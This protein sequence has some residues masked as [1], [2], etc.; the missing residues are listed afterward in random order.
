MSFFL[1]KNF[2]LFGKIEMSPLEFLAL[3]VVC[4]RFYYLMGFVGHLKPTAPMPFIFIKDIFIVLV[5]CSFFLLPKA[6]AAKGLKTL[7]AVW[8]TAFGAI[9][10]VHFFAK[11]FAEWGQ[12]Y[13]RNVLLVLATA[14]ALYRWAA[15]PKLF[16]LN[17]FL[18]WACAANIFAA[19]LQELFIPETMLGISRPLGLVGDPISLFAIVLIFIAVILT[20]QLSTMRLIIYSVICGYV[21]NMSASISA[22]L[23]AAAAAVPTVLFLYKYLNFAERKKVLLKIFICL[24]FLLAGLVIPHNRQYDNLT[25]RIKVL[26]NSYLQ[27]REPQSEADDLLYDSL[28]NGRAQS[29]EIT[30]QSMSSEKIENNLLAFWIGEYK[31]PMYRRVDSTP[32]VLI[33]NWGFALCML[34]YGTIGFLLI[35]W[36]KKNFFEKNFI[37]NPNLQ[38]LATDATTMFTLI[39]LSTLG[40]LNSVIYRSPLNFLLVLVVTKLFYILISKPQSE[41]QARIEH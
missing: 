20:Q 41:N 6:N 25:E 31:S 40:F 21:L 26:Y 29:L 10:C 27:K 30:K 13:V 11:P 16:N 9:A 35:F 22:C 18:F 33:I 32:A 39:S 4:G 17:R 12:H 2:K 36:M 8:L 34:F 37:N 24:T 5:I 1:E 19:L 23:S 14:P 7:L 38:T 15:N 3:L 28:K